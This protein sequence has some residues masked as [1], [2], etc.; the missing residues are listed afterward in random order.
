MPD[1][2]SLFPSSK[3]GFEL[4]EINENT[5]NQSNLGEDKFDNA[6]TSKIERVE[7]TDRKTK[8][9]YNVH[10]LSNFNDKRKHKSNNPKINSCIEM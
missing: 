4:E 7:D 9:K 3:S 2:Y 1:Y 8:P 6:D 10:E 5:I